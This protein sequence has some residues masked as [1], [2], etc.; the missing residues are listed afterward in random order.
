M[1]DQGYGAVKD[2]AEGE[3][4]LSARSVVT[5]SANAVSGLHNGRRWPGMA[6]WWEPVRSPLLPAKRFERHVHSVS[7]KMIAMWL[8]SCAGCGA[9][10]TVLSPTL[11]FLFSVTLKSWLASFQQSCVPSRMPGNTGFS[12]EP[13]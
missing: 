4:E 10:P 2:K 8:K 12:Q 11:P 3:Q 9:T 5:G 13:R 7:S 1:G 6:G